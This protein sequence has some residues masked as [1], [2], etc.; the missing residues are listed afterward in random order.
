[1]RIASILRRNAGVRACVFCVCAIS[2]KNVA[3]RIAIVSDV[4]NGTDHDHMLF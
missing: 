2:R 3:L 1:M 4:G